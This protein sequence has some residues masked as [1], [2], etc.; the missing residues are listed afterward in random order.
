MTQQIINVGAAPNDGQGNPIRTSFIKCNDNFNELYA[1]AQTDPP[2]ALTGQLGD[3]AGMYAYDAANFYYCFADYDGSSFIWGQVTQAGNV[4]ATQLLYGTT[5][6]DIASPGA[7]VTFQIAGTSNV[8]VVTSQLG[9]GLRSNGFVAATGN[10]VGD[11]LKAETGFVSAVGNV[12]GGNILTAGII[13]AAGNITADFF[14]GNSSGTFYGNSTTGNDAV[15]AGVPSFTVLG[16]NVVAQFSG[17]VNSYSQ[18][19]FENINSGNRAST[20][21]IA[22]ADNGNDSSN[23]VNMG[24]ASSTYN[25]PDFAAYGPND[26]YL[27]NN[28]GN[29]IINPET[30][31]KAINFIIGGTDVANIAGVMDSTGLVISGIVSASGNIRGANVNTVGLVTA[32]GNV[33]GGNIRTGGSISATGNIT[34]GN[35]SIGIITGTSVSVTG[36]ITGNYYVGNGAGLTGVIAAGN[37]GSASQLANG[38]SQFNIPVADGNVIGNIGGVVNVYTFTSTG[39]NVTGYVTATANITGGNIRTG[40]VVSATGNV[41]GGN[42]NAGNVSATGNIL[43]SSAVI[44]SGNVSASG[45]VI[46]GNLIVT[47]VAA[48]T[49][50]VTGGNVLTGGLIS[51]TGTITSAANITGGNIVTGGLITATGN[52]NA[53]NLTTAGRVLATGNVTGGNITTGGSLSALGNLVS[54]NVVTGG[55]ISATGNITGGNISATVYTGAAL[56]VTANVTGGNILTGGLISATGNVSGGNLNVTGNIVDTGALSIITGSNGNIALAPNG[57]GIVTVSTQVSTTGNVTGGN[58]L[59]AGLISATGNILTAGLISATG[60]ITGGNILGGA[61]VNAT[62]HTG[63]TVSVTA[64]ITGG[65]IL[66]GSGVVSGTGNVIGG[67]LISTNSLTVNSGNALTA[68]VNAAGNGVGNIGSSGSY[69][70]TIFAKATSAQYADL[71]ENYTSDAEYAPGTVVV[72]GGTAE[73]TTTNMFADVGVAGAISS[74]PAYLMNSGGKG[75]PVALRGRVPVRVIGPVTKGDLLVTAGQNPGYA[76]SV[77]RNTD[78]PLAVFAK[79]LETNTNEG[80]KVIEAVII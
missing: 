16:T 33:T 64:N 30:A 3:T 73:I 44:A 8:V 29:L 34:G 56:S 7:D 12:T 60:N 57:T 25:Y 53:A 37:V 68:I 45:N 63:T 42:V 14:V 55:L 23:Y 69:F 52:V 70:N 54:A 43:T 49:G 77:G 48:I 17:N 18:I 72:F 38:T 13:S 36:N 67:N 10:V 32:T 76:T 1:R 47:A 31:G 46:G 40:G 66:F 4:S 11:N 15:F 50:N 27:H 19:N 62:T 39:A 20:D 41:T 21:Y 35:L 51:A 26:A 65:N 24:I 6:V 79:A 22:T 75:L 80:T 74:N 5:V 59:T 58:I 61:N 2:G 28:G 71:A 9:G 78:R